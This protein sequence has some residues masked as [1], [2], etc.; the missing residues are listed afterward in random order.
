MHTLSSFSVRILNLVAFLLM[1]F[2]C[3]VV[4]NASTVRAAEMETS[5][6]IEELSEES[7]E[8]PEEESSPVEPVKS[9]V[10]AEN[11]QIYFYNED[12][13]VFNGGYK[14]VSTEDGV[15]YYFFQEDGTAFTG[16]YKPFQKDG[17]R[18]YYYFQADG[19]AYTDGYLSFNQGGKQYYFYFQEDGSA[20]TGGYKEV[21]IDGT[22]YSFYFLANGQGY[23]TGY[24][25][26][27]I[28]GKKYYLYFGDDGKAI[29]STIGSVP[30]GK[31]TAY[32][33]FN[34]KGFAYTGGY[35]E[36]ATGDKTDYYYFLQNGQ[37]FTTGY[38]TVKID[39]AT[40]Y[41]YFE[42][43]GRAY[44][45]GIKE[46]P[47]GSKSY[48]Y[49]FQDTGRALTSGWA[50]A[51]GDTYYLQENGR[52]AQGWFCVD[53]CCYYGNSNG[54][55]AT[56]TVIQGYKLDKEGR[57]P[58]KYR[59]MEYVKQHT[60]SSM[61]NQQKI[62]ALYNWVLKNDMNY[63]RTYEHVKA[64]WVWKNSWVDDMAASLMDNWG[65]NCFR[66]AS[67]LG[68]L[69]REATGLPV[70]VYHGDTPGAS[71]ALTP[72]GWVTVYQDGAWYS[73]DVELNKFSSAYNRDLCYKIPYTKS[74]G[75][76]YFN[77]VGTNLY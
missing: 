37:A 48:A 7:V 57:C 77:G 8:N 1:M 49:F 75:D 28:D 69:I 68:L 64:D 33:Y 40:N 72:H 29:T 4:L 76:M 70:V 50:N 51:G 35:K 66:Y 19:T 9:G 44:T 46:V 43:D 56:N 13:T 6:P 32:F 20:F 36:I 67:F 21:T 10:V 45:G 73:Y 23:N 25:T 24:K 54:A 42:D 52:A 38:K 60:N 16:G 62:E 31:R 74:K 58:T 12:G 17:K 14:E 63:I 30:L 47:F 59:I 65:G 11:G 41:F 55:I 53:Q 22:P 71:V 15:K 2:L 18:V 61:T 34:E 39:G 3:A 5:I 27:M 26:A